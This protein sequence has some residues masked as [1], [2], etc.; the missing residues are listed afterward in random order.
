MERTRRPR[1]SRRL[2]LT[3]IL[4]IAICVLV[5]ILA[6]VLVVAVVTTH[7]TQPTEPTEPSA[8]LG[9]STAPTTEPTEYIGLA[10]QASL[11]DRSVTLADSVVFEGTSDPSQPV[12]LNGETISRKE[13]GSF[14]YTASL[15]TGANEFVFA[16]KAETYTHAIE[17]RYAVESFS[18]AETTEYNCGATV[19]LALSVR[20]G[21]QIQVMLNGKEVEMKESENQVGSGISDGFV[22]FEGKYKLPNTNT[23]DVNLGPITYTVTCDGIT[24]TFTSGDIVCKKSADI[25]AS[26]PAVTPDYGEYID[27]GSGYIVEIINTTAET[28]DGKTNDDKSN[29]LRNY[30]PAG[31]VDYGSTKIITSPSGKTSYRLLRCGRRVYTESKNTPLSTKMP[32][33]D[34]YSGTLPD[35]NEVR[36][37]SLKVNGHHSILALDVLWKAP[38]YFDIESQN[39]R[40][41]ANRDF[42]ITEFTA[43]YID[44]TFCYATVFEGSLE[45]P[46]DNPLF[47]SAELIKRD[48]DCTLRLHLKKAGSFYGWDAYYN[49]NDQLCFRFLNPTPVQAAQNA[50]GADLTGITVMIDVGHGGF[51]PGAVGK[52]A[53]GNQVLESDRNLTLALALKAELE[54]IG[55]TVIMNRDTDVRLT[56]SERITF[57]KTQTP[58]ICICIH[59]NSLDQ[60]AAYYNG[61]EIS[62]FTPYSMELAKL[63][64]GYT[65][66]SGAYNSS[67]LLFFYSY[68]VSRQSV[69]PLVL[70]ENGY[71]SN[72]EEATKT[73]DPDVILA[74]AQAMTKGIAQY[75]LQQGQ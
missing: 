43:A 53:N 70:T 20:E 50:Y 12:T 74:K 16:H 10:V 5:V 11:P 36:L 71:L 45:I 6:A 35:H 33:V 23:A 15:T 34:C 54:S 24:E 59:H 18:P 13:D 48:S 60:S 9:E 19:Q 49:E 26:N 68:F 17:R 46:A 52:D 63:I 47:K 29:P 7:Q 28:F 75:F 42:S 31:T 37:D 3:Q 1:A 69:C 56:A 21:S 38:F 55:A 73:T 40:D 65:E 67:K 8:S 64:N 44:I 14:T 41:P 4:I 25:L 22:L 27:V 72:V 30:L 2:N 39:Y 62:Y 61:C 57:L 66:E 51:D 58:D 32:V